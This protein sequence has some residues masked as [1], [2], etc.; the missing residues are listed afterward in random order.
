MTHHLPLPPVVACLQ[1]DVTPRAEDNFHQVRHALRRLAPPPQSLVVLPELWLHGFVYETLA[2]QAARTA[3]VLDELRDLAAHYDIVL[4]GSLPEAR[5]GR[6]Y[7]SLFMVSPQGVEGRSDKQHPFVPMQEDEHF[8]PADSLEV[9]TVA[10]WCLGGLVCYD[11]RFPELARLQVQQGARLLVVCAQWPLARISHWRLLLQARAVENQ[12]F[13]VACNRVGSSATTRFG[14]HSIIIA[15]DGSLL[16]EAGEGREEISAAPA[17]ADVDEV[18][19]RF[20]SAAPRPWRLADKK[21]ITDVASLTETM[22]LYRQ[23]GQKVVFTNGCFDI[24]HEG[25]V[26]YLEAARRQGDRL[27]VGL[28][29][30]ASIRAIKGPKRPVN[31]ESSRARLL[32]A[33]GC[34]DHVVIFGE[35]TPLQLITTLL[36]DILVKGSDWP[37]DQIVG[38]REVLAAGGQVRTIEFVGDFSTTGLINK[39]RRD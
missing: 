14:G 38:A 20:N 35:D 3:G 27:V 2:E 15:P 11:L 9:M 18:R 25:H 29:S 28:N 36:P 10:G 5:Q 12:V 17:D 22:G 7:N 13:V 16:S 39:I 23:C 6:F 31:S 4:A 26:T 21:K 30:D 8:S 32:A 33:L 19:R 24:L 1:I 37:V 34:V